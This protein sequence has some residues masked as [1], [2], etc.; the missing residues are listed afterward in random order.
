MINMPSLFSGDILASVPDQH[1]PLFTIMI[2]DGTN[3]WT[4]Q[5]SMIVNAP[6]IEF[7][8]YTLFDSSGDGVFQPGETVTVTLN[9]SNTGHM[10]SGGGSLQVVLNSQY[11][12]I[13]NSLFTLP[14]MPIGGGVPIVFNVM[15]APNCPSSEIIALGVALD[16]GMQ[17]LNFN[18]MIPIEQLGKV[19]NPMVSQLFPG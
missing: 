18:L 7:G 2:S 15:I 11:A 3:E 1:A 17:L 5:R 4:T 13:D 19:L 16:A 6:N 14:P 10:N 8:N 9:L 12:T